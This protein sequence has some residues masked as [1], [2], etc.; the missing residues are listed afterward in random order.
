MTPPHAQPG[1]AAA[2]QAA[3][4]TGEHILVVD[5]GTTMTTA[6]LLMGGEAQPIPEPVAGARSWPSYAFVEPHEIV[7]G[8]L[9][10]GRRRND[11]LR[12]RAEFKR[13][14][15]GGAIS[16]E[17]IEFPAGD[18]RGG[19]PHPSSFPPGGTV[20]AGRHVTAGDLSAALLSAIRTEAERLAETAIDR[21]LVTCPGDFAIGNPDDQRWAE[22]DDACR[23]AGFR[24]IEYLH[25]PVAA[26][27]A[28]ISGR[29]PVPGQLLLVY[30]FGGGTF[31]AAVVR[32]SEDHHHV[33]AA[34]SLPDCGGADVD[35]L[36]LQ[37]I[38]GMSG[39]EGQALHRAESALRIAARD[40]KHQL[41]SDPSCLVDL[42]PLH[43][44]IRLTRDRLEELV[45]QSG[46][47][48]R[49]L[50]LV[51]K[52]LDECGVSREALA[53]VLLVGGTSRM[54]MVTQLL[55]SFTQFRPMDIGCAVVDGA[56]A[57]ARSAPTRTL[58]P[59][60]P[61]PDLVPL[62]WPLPQGRATLSR[63]LAQ[64]G[65]RL[66]DGAPVA[67]VSLPDGTLWDL[68]THMPGTLVHQH[69]RQGESFASEDWLAS[70]R[71]APL[72]AAEDGLRILRPG[73]RVPATKPCGPVAVSTDGTRLARVVAPGA[74]D[75]EILSLESGEPITVIRMGQPVTH[76]VMPGP[77]CALLASSE[78]VQRWASTSG[79]WKPTWET[80]VTVKA[81]MT[82]RDGS[83]AGGISDHYQPTTL[84]SA[85]SEG[86]D[87]ARAHFNQGSGAWLAVG[88][89][90]RT[91]V[92]AGTG[93][94]ELLR[95]QSGSHHLVVLPYAICATVAPVSGTVY[96]SAP[97]ED[98]H[99]RLGAIRSSTWG[100]RYRTMLWSL[101]GAV[102]SAMTENLPHPTYLGV[103]SRKATVPRYHD[104]GVGP[105]TQLACDPSGRFIAA[106]IGS[107]MVVILRIQDLQVVATTGWLAEEFVRLAFCHGGGRLAL[108]AKD[109]SATVWAAADT[110]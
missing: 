95:E 89:G 67:R 69:R 83:F 78:K 1:A 9:A 79:V 59:G 31:D 24:D 101:Q 81:L 62:C 8:E 74:R 46:L 80:G 63:W 41:S 51:D 100:S 52:L 18:H 39:L 84:G 23:A 11:P 37:E 88:P 3:D 53:G 17:Y 7:V 108:V 33:I 30:D 56:T 47:L 103:L 6:T 29:P 32:I 20:P 28:P 55:A 49:T 50:I 90:G 40:V 70:V 38:V 36:I 73:M 71:A 22:L 44:G 93:R 15:G 12:F 57:W 75:V 72:G 98:F 104:L 21:L 82:D 65:E 77:D 42:G 45:H 87:P 34:D 102:D 96:F 4:P 68:R 14:L 10:D 66:A 85:T 94:S 13:R 27:F 105:V 43:E 99:K 86:W 107:R 91:V 16:R 19:P 5:L 25:E 2:G 48:E 92:A 110:Q 58:L 106:G 60:R 35:A 54:P 97:S 76:V 26:A 61:A 109:G 64:P